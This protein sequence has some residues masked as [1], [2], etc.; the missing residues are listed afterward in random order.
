MEIIKTKDSRMTDYE[1]ILMR[2]DALMKEGEQYYLEY[3]RRFGDLINDVFKMKIE[4]IAKKKKISYCQARANKGLPIHEDEMNRYIDSTMAEYYDQLETML[5]N[6]S[7]AKEG[8]TVSY[9]D[10]LKIKEIYRYLVKLIHPDV[11]L[12]LADDQYMK[13]IWVQ[14][15]SAYNFNRLDDLEE[16]KFKVESYLQNIGDQNIEIIISDLEEKIQ[17]IQEE[18]M[19]IMDSLPYLYHLILDSETESNNRKKEL[20]EELQ[21]YSEYSLQLDEV[22]HAFQIERYMS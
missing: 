13:K 20:Q 18:I 22:L 21:N 8:K 16:L 12:D 2:K 10:V 3:I 19:H 6:A 9:A 5:A 17:K 15:V 7:A 11:R 4:C 14:I 1:N